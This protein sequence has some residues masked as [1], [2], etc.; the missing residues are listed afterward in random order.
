MNIW[1]IANFELTPLDGAKSSRFQTIAEM[2]R[3]RD[4]HVTFYSSTFRHNT[5]TVR[6]EETTAIAHEPGYDIIFV[7][8][9][10]YYDNLSMKRLRAH[11]TFA[12]NI[13][14]E[15]SKHPKPDAIMMTMPPVS[16][17]YE[18]TRWAKRNNVPVIIDIIDP[19]P[20]VLRNGMKQ[21]PKALQDVILMPMS[22]RIRQALRSAS[23]ITGIS[24]AY[25]NWAS[26]YAP[27]VK[28][29]HVFYPA[30]KLEEMQEVMKKH[31]SEHPSPAGQIRVIYAGSFSSSYDLP[32]ILQAA[33][34]LNEKYG[35]AIQFSIAGAGPQT[36]LVKDYESRLSNLIY[37]GRLPKEDLLVEY[38]R[39][40]IGLTQHIKGATQSVTYKLFDLLACGLPIMN[41]L[42]SEMKDI[43]ND[44][45]VGFFNEPG[46]G[47]QLA[48]NIEKLYLDPALLNQMKQAALD[49][50]ARKGDAVVVYNKAVD[51]IEKIGRPKKS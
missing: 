51:L 49:L 5:K 40:D 29:L 19:W 12:K 45:G 44:N 17:S 3:L 14:E 36:D 6:Y 46:N 22:S 39:A 15:L 1:L 33:E 2:A 27:E 50:T 30:R 23:A 20:D 8:S 24:Q 28:E 31:R 7:K 38:A 41:S 16:L 42:E 32:A 13:A 11:Y 26:R 9:P 25:I 18:V 4:H 35:D 47:R 48:E 10:A 34:I 43:I 37:L 21:V